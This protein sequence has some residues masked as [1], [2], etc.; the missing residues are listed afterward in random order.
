MLPESPKAI[1]SC[2]MLTAPLL[3]SHWVPSTVGLHPA[4]PAASC[5]L[6]SQELSVSCGT[7][8]AAARARAGMHWPPL[9]LANPC[10]STVNFNQKW[11]V[12]TRANLSLV[13]SAGFCTPLIIAPGS[14]DSDCSFGEG[15][16][17]KWLL[18]GVT[19]RVK[20]KGSCSFLNMRAL[21][22]MQAGQGK[23]FP[24]FSR[25]QLFFLPFLGEAWCQIPPL[26]IMKCW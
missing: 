22:N 7:T 12:Q 10:Y 21:R 16:H 3:P 20:F 15:H 17:C 5:P 4:V 18:A 1:R 2:V 8:T 26:A 25:L 11:A 14:Y 23:L 13:A 6:R 9:T 24:F 19:G